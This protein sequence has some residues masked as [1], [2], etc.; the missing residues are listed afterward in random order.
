M[1][2]LDGKS[3]SEKLLQS[4]KQE[5]D[6]ARKEGQRVPHLGIILVG[7]NPASKTYVENKCRVAR[8]VGFEVSQVALPNVVTEAELL[9]KIDAFNQDDE[10]DGYIVQLPL[11]KHINEQQVISRIDPRKD[12]DG[13]HP[14]NIGRLVQGLEAFV[15]ATPMGIL[16]L[17]ETYDVPIKGKRCVVLGLDNIVGRPLA[18]VLSSPAMGCTVTFLHG[19]VEDVKDY[20]QR[21][22]VI[23]TALDKPHFLKADMVKEGVTIV[24]V[25]MTRQTADN[26]KGYQV[27]GDVDF[28]QVA[29]KCAYISP[30]PGGVGPMTIIS[31]LQNTMKAYRKR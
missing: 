24:D 23:I 31:L 1:T 13:F 8:S 28:E 25:G 7:D 12:V 27:V 21:A 15:S 20:T 2:V 16:N 9:K 14:M 19:L 4:I 30:V 11:P 17:L 5:V 3:A 22:D 29:P 18:N 10:V 26:E 6:E